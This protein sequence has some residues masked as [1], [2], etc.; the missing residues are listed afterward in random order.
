MADLAFHEWSPPI[1]VLLAM[2]VEAIAGYPEALQRRIAHP[3][4]WIGAVIERLERA[5]NSPDIPE[6]TRRSLGLATL[7]IVGGGAAV[8]GAF[9]QA[10]LLRL[11]GDPLIFALVASTGFARKSLDQHVRAVDTALAAH[12]L[13]GARAAVGRIVGRDTANLDEAGVAAA[14]LESLAESFNDGIVAPAFWLLV[15]GLPGLFA[16]KAVNTADSMI[17]H[18]EPRWRAFGEASAR[19]DD[20]M[21][22]IPARIAGALIV[23]AARGRGWAVMRRDAKLHASPNAG[24]PEAAMAGALGVSLGGPATYDGVASERPVLGEGARP[25]PADL[26]RGLGLFRIAYILLAVLFVVLGIAWPR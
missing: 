26:A 18:K 4:V 3:V 11:F 14:A 16:Y 6:A 20:L 19:T 7:A 5:W 15:A 8:I 25:S 24:W 10:L 1:R 23:A 12:D 9:L 13:P 21:N 22:L 17:G 2:G